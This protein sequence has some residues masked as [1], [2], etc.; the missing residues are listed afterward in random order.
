M[1][2]IITESQ[3]RNL[4]KENY[5]QEINLI[6][7]ILNYKTYE[8]VC[9]YAFVDDEETNKV[10]SVIVVFS[11]DWYFFSEGNDDF[12]LNRKRRAIEDTKL[13]VRNVIRKYLGM[14]NVYVG[15]VIEEC[16]PSLNEQ[17]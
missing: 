15:S 14:N 6:K 7:K 9:D 17:E 12:E 16:N 13:K 10:G 3:Y 2:Y 8:G 1:K 5:K 11:Q 4:L